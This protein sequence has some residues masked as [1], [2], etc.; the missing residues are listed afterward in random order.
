MV[1]SK[2]PP[3]ARSRQFERADAVV[4][5]SANVRVQA[6]PGEGYSRGSEPYRILLMTLVSASDEELAARALD[7]HTPPLESA[8]IVEELLRRQ[9]A[10]GAPPAGARRAL[11]EQLG[12]ARDVVDERLQVARRAKEDEEAA[13]RLS[14]LNGRARGG[15]IAPLGIS[16]YR[17]VLRLEPRELR[18]EVLDVLEAG[19]APSY[20]ELL[21][22]IDTVRARH[23]GDATNTAARRGPTAV[24]LRRIDRADPNLGADVVVPRL[25]AALRS[26]GARI[27]GTR[28]I[29]LPAT[30]WWEVLIGDVRS[31]E[32]RVAKYIRAQKGRRSIPL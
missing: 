3:L 1:W 22:T 2:W 26:M 17:A 20:R 11:S 24:G 9:V 7:V 13:E 25:F 6:F 31:L 27:E 21:Q 18:H 10:G 5:S 28:E 12:V 23:T 30:I 4:G 8:G 19:E 14:R 32:Q 15:Y 29:E 16:A